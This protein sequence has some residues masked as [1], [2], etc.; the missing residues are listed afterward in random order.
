MYLLKILILH[1]LLNF[2]FSKPDHNNSSARTG[3]QELL[4]THYYCEENEQKNFFANMQLTKSLNVNPNHNQSK[5]TNIIV[6]LYSKARA[7]TLTGYN[8]PKRKYIVPKSQT[9]T[10][11][12]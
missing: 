11:T 8:F 4:L 12:E 5:Q 2:N 1:T 6:T 10:E 3:P 9:E 7:T